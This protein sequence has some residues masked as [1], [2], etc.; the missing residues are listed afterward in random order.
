MVDPERPYATIWPSV[1]E[2]RAAPDANIT[3]AVNN[4]HWVER[5]RESRDISTLER[6]ANGKLVE[7]AFERDQSSAGYL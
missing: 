3:T 6:T 5:S 7:F 2:H 4:R 1:S